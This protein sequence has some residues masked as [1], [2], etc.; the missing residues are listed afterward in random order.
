MANIT[1]PASTAIAL[2]NENSSLKA[3]I[4]KGKEVARKSAET[5]ASVGVDAGSAL[6]ASFGMGLARGHFEKEGVWSIPG[7]TADVGL[8]TGAVLLGAALA[9][10]LSPKQTK[11]SQIGSRVAGMAGIGILAHWSGQVGRKY[12]GSGFKN[13]SLVAGQNSGLHTL[14]N[15]ST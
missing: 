7:T 9:V 4:A 11:E 6:L 2:R 13:F 12:A 1:M 15:S 10:S 5:V 14:L 8:A 3:R